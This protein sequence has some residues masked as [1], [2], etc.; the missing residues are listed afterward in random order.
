MTTAPTFSTPTATDFQR[1]QWGR[2]LIVPPEGGA[3][4]PYTRA[5]AAAKTIEDTYNLELWARRNVVFGMARDPSLVARVLALGGDPSTW[6]MA[7][8]KQAN[9][10]HE[11]AADVALA[12]KAADIGTAVHRMT[13]I[14]DRNQ[15]LIAGPY[16]ADISAYVNALA[17][18]GYEVDPAHIEC[19]LV[20]D[21][22]RM[23]GSADRILTR[24]ADR[25]RL[26]ADIKTGET[27]D[28]GGLGWAAQLAAYAHSQLYDIDTGQRVA[29]PALERTTGIIIHLPAGKGICTL[30]EID[31][32]AGY[33]AAQLA[34]EIRAVRREARRWITPLASAAPIAEAMDRHPSTGG[35]REELRRR[36]RELTTTARDRFI[37]RAIDV[38]DLDAIEGAL[39]ELEV[40]VEADL[41][42]AAPVIAPL[43]AV[44]TPRQ[45]H[46]RLGRG[47]DEGDE[48]DDDD[49]AALRA[50]HDR[51]PDARQMWLGSI[52]AEANR[53]GVAFYLNH[54]RTDRRRQIY[55]A[56]MILAEHE[57][58]DADFV[59]ALAAVATDSDAPLY[60]TVTVGHAVGAMGAT[61]AL[62]FRDACTALAEDRLVCDWTT[63]PAMRLVP[64]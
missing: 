46:D 13:E 41:G 61:E 23:A 5:S 63:G 29:T 42:T 24:T 37:E 64:V 15:P 43:A 50:R 49:Y 51:L 8:K 34:N 19:R 18:A 9:K 21:E 54:V 28:Y 26:I 10:I 12:H 7:T 11:D 39:D 40:E 48:I 45:I 60:P 56:L 32:V 17:A 1:D 4:V 27:V 38:D 33:R 6:D 25:A 62:A 57:I 36:Y 59:R 44:P 53:A 52:G 14:V 16:E 58:D 31:L 2:P 47:H 22:L 20:C 35:R 55:T 3:P 30:Y